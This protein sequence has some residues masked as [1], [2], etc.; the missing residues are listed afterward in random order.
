M[1]GTWEQVDTWEGMAEGMV[2]IG[3]MTEADPRRGPR[4]GHGADGFHRDW[5]VPPLHRPDQHAGRHRL[6][7]RWRIAEDGTLAGMGFFVEG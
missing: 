2:V 6:A 5:R 1:E 7:G 4:L 3:E